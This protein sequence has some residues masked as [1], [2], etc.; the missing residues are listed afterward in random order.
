MNIKTFH[1]QFS[2]PKCLMKHD[3]ARKKLTLVTAGAE[4]PLSKDYMYTNLPQQE[5]LQ[6]ASQESPYY[7]HNS[8]LYCARLPLKQALSLHVD[9]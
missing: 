7:L 2:L 6:D 5:N 9:L 3:I 4:R 8:I 1:N